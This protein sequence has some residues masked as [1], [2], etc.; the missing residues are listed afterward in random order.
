MKF[1]TQAVNATIFLAVLTK[2]SF[3]NAKL[4]GTQQR[5]SRALEESDVPVPDLAQ[6]LAM[7]GIESN[8]P[9][10]QQDPPLVQG[11][12]PPLLQAG[13][14]NTVIAAFPQD[15]YEGCEQSGNDSCWS[16]C[17]NSQNFDENNPAHQ[18]ACMLLVSPS[19]P[20]GIISNGMY[21]LSTPLDTKPADAL[22]KISAQPTKVFELDN[23]ADM[24]HDGCYM[25][26]YVGSTEGKDVFYHSQSSYYS[27]QQQ[28]DQSDSSLGLGFGPIQF[29]GGYSKT[30]EKN[31]ESS[32]KNSYSTANK[33][34]V[35]YVGS[36]ANACVTD[37]NNLS[38]Y[39]S[40]S[41]LDEWNYANS[42]QDANL[43]QSDDKFRSL[44]SAGMMYPTL[45]YFAVGTSYQMTF[46]SSTTQSDTS[47]TTDKAHEEGMKLAYDGA[48]ADASNKMSNA[49]TNVYKNAFS[50]TTV[51]VQQKTFGLTTDKDSCKP[52]A[53]NGDNWEDNLVGCMD[54]Y[55]SNNLKDLSTAYDVRSFVD[56]SVY[57]PSAPSSTFKEAL[58]LYLYHCDSER[59]GLNGEFQCYNGDGSNDD[60]RAYLNCNKDNTPGADGTRKSTYPGTEIYAYAAVSKTPTNFDPLPGDSNDDIIQK[61]CKAAPV[62]GVKL[63]TNHTSSDTQIGGSSRSDRCVKLSDQQN[64]QQCSDYCA[65][66]PGCNGFWYYD[67]GRCCAKSNWSNDFTREIKGGAFYALPKSLPAKTGCYTLLN[68]DAASWGCETKSTYNECMAVDP[69]VWGMETNTGFTNEGLSSRCGWSTSIGD[70]PLEKDAQNTWNSL[71]YVQKPN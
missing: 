4:R 71:D 29:S 8:P 70:S 59:A 53:I 58:N 54:Y 11:G 37:K 26:N 13:A 10:V 69:W 16:T 31:T 7:M 18:L 14:S 25:F 28:K 17:K 61:V 63:S 43:L 48:T 64:V 40:T 5:E 12:T 21:P 47:S 24:I 46:H 34:R 6:T 38:K 52:S 15:F 55:K 1:S 3:R 68:Q 22:P 45:H 33:D 67:S 65:S 57:M 50:E 9:V 35:G 60:S 62:V 30:T 39:I 66:L 41:Y 23:V 20:A 36:I 49:A 2:P 32:G 19:S 56:I 51:D 27:Q 42:I 44:V